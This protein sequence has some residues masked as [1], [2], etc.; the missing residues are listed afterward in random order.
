MS[1]A[2]AEIRPAQPL[3]LRVANELR[4]QV[5]S[6]ALRVGEKAPSIRASSRRHDVSISTVLQA[7]FWLEDRGYLEARPRSGFYVRRPQAELVPEPEF[8]RAAGPPRQ[9]GVADTLLAILRPEAETVPLALGSASPAPEL[10]PTA[11]INRALRQVIRE[12]PQHSALYGPTEGVEELRRQVAR[13]SGDFGCNFAPGEVVVT[14][15]GMEALQLALRAAARPGDLVAIE[16]PTYFGVLQ[17]IESL[18]MK[19]I[20]VPTH[21]HTGLDLD[22]LERAIRKHRVKACV[23]MPNGHN[24]LGYVLPAEHSRALVELCARH[25]VAVIEDDVFGDLAHGERRG[26]AAKSFDRDGSVIMC[27]SFSKTLG[28]GL[29]VGWIQAGRFQQEVL[30]LKSITTLSTPVLSQYAVVRMLASGGYDRHLRR[31]RL[32]FAE[33]VRRVSEAV[34]RYFPSGTRLTRPE[35]GFLLWVQLPGKVDSMELYRRAAAHGI[36]VMPGTVFSA[37]PAFRSHIRLSC[38][39]PWSNELDAALKTLGRLCRA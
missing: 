2:A 1:R 30:R 7:Y 3:Y 12:H 35:A 14:S 37:G 32:V 20:E 24:P 13:R 16:S 39:H 25:G 26:R 19:A 4:E 33:Q 18:S 27:G 5:S 28:A 15:G 36:G 6:G 31:L 21:P 23:T 17:S 38:G 29:R 11:R 8:H 10:L 9:V 22:A 34:R